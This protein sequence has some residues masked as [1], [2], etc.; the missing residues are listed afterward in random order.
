MAAAEL[1]AL[2][3]N[4]IQ[5]VFTA[6]ERNQA[7]LTEKCQGGEQA[8]T[9]MSDIYPNQPGK[10]ACSAE[11]YVTICPRALQLNIGLPASTAAFC[12]QDAHDLLNNGGFDFSTRSASRGMRDTSELNLKQGQVANKL[13]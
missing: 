13:L 6:F 8:Q 3:T 4:N 12:T 10:R 2:T 5:V 1:S 9:A 11:G 7:L